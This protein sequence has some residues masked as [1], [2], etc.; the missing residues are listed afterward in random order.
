M[1]VTGSTPSAETVIEVRNLV[2]HY[3]ERRIL[4]DVSV[5]VRAGEVLVI[6]GGSGSGKS[7]LLRFLLGLER[8]TAGHVRILGVDVENAKAAELVAEAAAYKDAKVAEATGEAQRFSALLVEYRRAPEI[9]RK[10]LYLE[11]MEEVLPGVEKVII[12]PGSTPVLPYLPLGS[13]ARS[14]GAGQ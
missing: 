9:T 4:D 14:A 11:T 2:T 8:P 5:D 3:G 7:T 12:E 10:R 1:S 13:A 6:M